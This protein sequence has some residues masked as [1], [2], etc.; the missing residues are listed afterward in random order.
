LGER[1]GLERCSGTAF[2]RSRRGEEG[3]PEAV[4]GGTPAATIKA[5]W[6]FGGRPLREGE[7]EEGAGRRRVS[8]WRTREEWEE[9]R[10]RGRGTGEAVA[11]VATGWRSAGGRSGTTLTGGSRPPVRV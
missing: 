5:R 11:C 1:C 2:Y 8:V 3:A 9:A 4:G 10:G 7:E 6:S